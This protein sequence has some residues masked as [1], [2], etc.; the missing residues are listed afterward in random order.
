MLPSARSFS[1]QGR[2]AIRDSGLS[3]HELGKRADVNSEIIHRFAAGTRGVTAPSFDRPA[4][5]FSPRAVG[6]WG[7]GAA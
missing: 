4:D 6:A 3:V 7:T 2:D 5:V 1:V